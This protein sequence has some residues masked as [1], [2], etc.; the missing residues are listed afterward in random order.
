[1]AYLLFIY[2]LFMKFKVQLILYSY[3]LILEHNIYFDN[4]TLLYAL[5]NHFSNVDFKDCD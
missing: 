4:E 3:H 1:M 2:L 5:N